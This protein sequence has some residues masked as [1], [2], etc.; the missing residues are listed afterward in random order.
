M[1]KEEV[2]PR[3][4]QAFEAAFDGLPQKRFDLFGRRIAE[5][6]FAGDAHPVGHA[7]GEGFADDLFGLAVTVARRQIDQV[8][9]GSHRRKYRGDAFVECRF[10]PDHADAAATQRQRRDRRK[11]TKTVLPHECRLLGIR[12]AICSTP[13]AGCHPGQVRYRAQ[14]RDI[15]QKL[16]Y[17]PDKRLTG[18]GVDTQPPP[19]RD[20]EVILIDQLKEI[21]IDGVLEP[22][23]TTQW[24][25]RIMRKDYTV[26]LNVTGSGV[27]DPDQLF[28]E[29][30]VC[31][32]GRNYTGYC[33]PA[34]DKLVDQQSMESDKEKA[35]ATGLGNRAAIGSGR[36]PARHLLSSWRNLPGPAGEGNNGK[37]QQ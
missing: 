9:P 21:Y 4:S 11:L 19:Y 27:D 16:G 20:P 13:N 6:A 33:T 2:E 17:G 1:E 32:S 8:D 7:A 18:Y 30:Y 36:R 34:V 23:D 26:G 3:Q 37:A 10:A 29:N 31:G 15:M 35:R 5:I 22:V 12:A 28:Y 25:P 24:Y 14:A